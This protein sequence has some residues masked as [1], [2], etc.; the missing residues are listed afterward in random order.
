MRNSQPESDFWHLRKR[1]CKSL[2]CL[3]T[4]KGQIILTVLNKVPENLEAIKC[5]AGSAVIYNAR[6]ISI[7]QSHAIC[8]VYSTAE[9]SLLAYA[10]V[11]NRKLISCSFLFECK[12][13]GE[14]L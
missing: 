7:L 12:N 9:R 1:D 14:A 3:A 2:Q 10:L 6:R 13:N 4:L 5:M 8:L 11:P